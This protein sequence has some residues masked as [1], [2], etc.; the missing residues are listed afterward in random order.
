MYYYWLAVVWLCL[1]SY[2]QL[3]NKTAFTKHEE[4]ARRD[5][6]EDVSD[7]WRFILIVTSVLHR[8]SL[9]GFLSLPWILIFNHF[10]YLFCYGGSDKQKAHEG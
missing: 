3:L 6:T 2:T 9:L 5:T 7:L 4:L 8:Y 10:Y 1:C